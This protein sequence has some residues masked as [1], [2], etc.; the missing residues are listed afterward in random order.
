MPAYRKALLLFAF[1]AA[2][3]PSGCSDIVVRRT[4]PPDLLEEWRASVV[5][6]GEISART[7]QT[8]RRYDLVNVYR[9]SPDRAAERL[10]SEVLADPQPDLLFALAEINYLRGLQA[11]KW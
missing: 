2:C 4:K 10:H 6:G 11:E 5:N 9:R 1:A 7:K 8:L 3:A